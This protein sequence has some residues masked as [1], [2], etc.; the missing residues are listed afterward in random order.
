MNYYKVKQETLSNNGNSVS[1]DKITT[2]RLEKVQF[3][4][5]RIWQK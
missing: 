2:E 4:Y 3:H 5:S 1:G